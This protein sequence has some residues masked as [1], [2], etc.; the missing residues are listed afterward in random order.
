MNYSQTGQ[1]AD[2]GILSSLLSVVGAGDGSGDVVEDTVGRF[3][4]NPNDPMNCGFFF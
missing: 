4:K 1:I 2:V 3:K